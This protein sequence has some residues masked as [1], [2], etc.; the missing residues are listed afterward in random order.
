MNLINYII[1]KVSMEEE[2]QLIGKYRMTYLPPK[3][4]K[5]FLTK[6][7]GGVIEVDYKDPAIYV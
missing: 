7:C 6:H 5:I 3:M 1:E 4:Q 2:L